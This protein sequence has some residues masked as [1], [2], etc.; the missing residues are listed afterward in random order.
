MK[1]EAGAHYTIPKTVTDVSRTLYFY[2]GSTL[3]IDNNQIKE[4]HLIEVNPAVDLEMKSGSE[5]AY[6]LMLQGK[7]IN[8]PVA[9]HGP[10]VMNTQ[11]EIR[12]AFQ[13]YQRTQFGGWPWPMQEQMHDKDKGRFALHADGSEEKRVS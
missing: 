7:P 13:D 5:D 11:D 4:Y 1:L 12:E 3:E 8:E 10:F 6:I 9:Q 2:K